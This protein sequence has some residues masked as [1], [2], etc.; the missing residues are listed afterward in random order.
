M[1][2]IRLALACLAAVYV[3]ACAHKPPPV[4][5]GCELPAYKMTVNPD[6][7]EFIGPTVGSPADFAATLNDAFGASKSAAP[8]PDLLILSGGSQ[9]GAFGAGFL[10]GLAHRDGKLPNYRV[11]TGVSTGALLSTLAFLANRAHPTDRQYPDYVT[12][13]GYPANNLD[14]LRKVFSIDSEDRILNVHK[15]SIFAGLSKGSLATFV[16]LRQLIGGILSTQTLEQIREEAQ[17]RRLIVGVTSLHDGRAYAIDLTQFVA[18]NLQA[19]SYDMVRECYIDALLASST[20]PPA[21][22]PVTLV[23]RH[24]LTHS[25]AKPAMFIDG[26][27]RFGVFW[28][29]LQ[30]A[31]LPNL[32]SATMIINGRFYT[33][34]WDDFEKAGGQWSLP[35]VAMRSVGILTNQIYRFSVDDAER[36]FKQNGSLEMAFISDENLKETYQSSEATLPPGEYPGG[37]NDATCL[38]AYEN[39]KKRESPLEFYAEYMRCM[40]NYGFARGSTAPWN[41]K[42]GATVQAPR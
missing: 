3:A 2:Y 38:Q 34:D 9:H 4:T 26:G 1:R 31:N 12:R 6:H 29:Q 10:A 40:V 8:E 41:R 32:K 7:E 11:V 36:H 35:S 15:G 13:H 23:L 30:N 28:N 33:D 39:D 27:A 22:P 19:G 24:P 14:A 16:P 42:V 17:T 37:D 21:M 25:V 20:V 5:A 18:R